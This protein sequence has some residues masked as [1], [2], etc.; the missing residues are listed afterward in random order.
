[1][2]TNLPKNLRMISRGIDTL[3]QLN[4]KK[5][6]NINNLQITTDSDGNVVYKDPALFYQSIDYLIHPFTKQKVKNLTEY[7]ME[8]W[9]DII[10]YKYNIDIKSNKNRL[11][12]MCLITLYQNCM[13]KDSAGNEKLVICQTQ[14]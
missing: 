8:F 2:I 5:R 10:S 11:T 13:P 12:T 7:Q 6:Y 4:I 14:Q 1:M 3:N 9:K